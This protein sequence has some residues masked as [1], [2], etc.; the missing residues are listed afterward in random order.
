[1]KFAKKLFAALLASLMIV[2]LLATTASAETITI[3]VKNTAEDHV[4]AAYQVFSGTLSDAGVLS[5]VQWGSG[6]GDGAGLLAA[7][8]ADDTFKEGGVNQFAAATDAA[9][10]A[11]VLGGWSYNDPEVKA[12]ADAVVEFKSA[13]CVTSAAQA[14]GK[15]VITVPAVGYYLVMDTQAVGGAD[16][17][18]DYLLQVVKSVE[19]APK[20]SAPTFNKSVNYEL[21]STYG[22]A[23]DAQ[24]GDTVYFKLET[25]L[26]SLFEDY[27]QYVMIMQDTMPAGLKFKQVED[28]YVAHAKGGHTSYLTNY[29][30]DNAANL[31][32]S[33]AKKYG[34]DNSTGKL[35][36]NFG[37][38]KL[39]N[40]I[41]A[42]ND[43][44]VVKYS[45]TVTDDVLFGLA[46]GLGNKNTATMY[47]SN[48]MNQNAAE[49]A[50][51]NESEWQ[52]GSITD[53]ASVYS[54]QLEITKKDGL[55][56]DIL[57]GAEFYLYRDVADGSG[58]TTKM[59]AHTDAN[60]VI[61]SWS[62]A[63]P[64]RKLVSGDTDGDGEISDAE[65]TANTGKV[66]IKGLDALSYY[67]EEVKA[68]AGY[69]TPK[70][71]LLVNIT[72][73]FTGQE[74][75][76]LSGS[77]D[78]INGT[79]VIDTGLVSVTVNNTAGATLPTTG[80]I[81]TTIFY[82]VG[83]VLVLGAAAAFTMKKRNEA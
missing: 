55:S 10:V 40:Q 62:T 17:A 57:T 51:V 47:F 1:M 22:K 20:V 19:V 58:N 27:K 13:V 74:L 44:I 49:F 42:V 39:N 46:G 45:A 83:G 63:T 54:Y 12:F 79:S 35:T 81:G 36:I 23:I 71:P 14:D 75:T 7:L 29:V 70:A 56:G 65:K 66:V 25:K 24:V 32:L 76:S 34:Y 73:G 77:V 11:K 53:Y 28:I 72:S 33:A 30:E 6:I 8:K 43:T 82:I 50:G 41:S 2:G 21:D 15:Y 16:A 64:A 38:I 52:H 26:P 4:Y 78:G 37:D 31:S 9:G 3:T 67:L 69:N 48:N 18:T 59:Y 5:D 60:G 61:T 80:G 68:P